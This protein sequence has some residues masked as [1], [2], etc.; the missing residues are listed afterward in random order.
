[1][2]E[3]KATMEQA[4]AVLGADSPTYRKL[5]VLVETLERELT[6]AFETAAA[7]LEERDIRL[8]CAILTSA[9]PQSSAAR[10]GAQA[11]RDLAK[12]A[13]DVSWNCAYC[14]RHFDDQS[15]I[16]GKVCITCIK[17]WENFG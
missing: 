9:P 3:S 2:I 4:R 10:R 6:A 13:P 15:T 11:I 5:V 7:R 12:L 8:D 17:D 1:M 16:A 14:D